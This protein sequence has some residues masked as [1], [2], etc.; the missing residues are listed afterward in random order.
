VTRPGYP[1]YANVLRSLGVE[2]VELPVGPSTG[3]Q[4]TV[5]HLEQA[6]G[7]G[8]RL[9]GLVLASPANPTGSMVDR[10]RLAEL[11]GWCAAHGVRLISD[12]IYHGITYDPADGR[13]T[14]AREVDPA[15]VVVS[16]FSKYWGMT[17]WRLGWAIVPD[18]LLP[19]VDALAGNVALCPPA[20]PQEA[21]L[22][23]FTERSYAEADARVAGLAATRAVLLAS[24]ERLGWGPIAPP[25]G[26]FYL[27]AG[28]AQQL[29]P[30][31]D[32]VAWC[33]ALLDEAGVAL[34]P[35]TD[36][37][38]VDGA[39]YVRLS[40]AAGAGAVAEAVDRIVAWQR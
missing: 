30:H 14:C 13:G 37:D 32:S 5:E 7:S 4:P 33:R 25:S 27:W 23:A 10:R 17:G 8:S 6:G 20:L 40:F 28:I 11:A 39:T 9:D 22:G 18:D 21:A 15:A 38:K 2:A 1:A 16:S 12:E 19:A 35:G 36:M 24:L 29:G 31:A 34:V 3:F 26:A